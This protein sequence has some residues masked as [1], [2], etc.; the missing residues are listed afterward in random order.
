MSNIWIQTTE[1]GR[2]WKRE[3][4]RVNYGK[5]KDVRLARS[6]KRRNA[7]RAWLLVDS[8]RARA[9]L[10]NLPFDLEGYQPELQRRMDLG[11]CEFSGIPLRL[12]GGRTFDSP[13]LDR[14]VPSL[15]YT[16]G[17]VRIVCDIVNR[18]LNDYGEEVLFLV[19]E[20]ALRKLKNSSKPI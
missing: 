11:V 4:D 2:A 18:A 6:L 9:K 14:I 15:G 10:R 3:Y 5:Q 13:S 12:T 16:R 1:E 17:N 8:A 7:K 19:M 20:S